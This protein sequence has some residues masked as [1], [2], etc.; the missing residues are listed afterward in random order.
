MSLPRPVRPSRAIADF[1]AYVR[2]MKRSQIWGGVLAVGVTLLWFWAIFDKLY[3]PEPY[4]PP[5][6][7]YVTQW[8]ATRTAEEVR[9]QQARDLP[10]ELAEKKRREEAEAARRA[11]YD[12]LAKQLGME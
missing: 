12:R 9:A 5:E 6:V 7:S 1:V 11:Q 8:P 10:R 4:K 2:Q 3:P